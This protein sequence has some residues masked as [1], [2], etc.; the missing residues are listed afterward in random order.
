MVLAL[1]GGAI[2]ILLSLWGIKMF[3]SVVP[4][5]MLRLDQVGLDG[6]V[7]AYAILLTVGC[8]LVF[9]T[10]PALQG[11]GGDLSGGLRDGGRT[12]SVGLKHGR[13]RSSLVMGEIA[14]ALVLLISAGLLV[15]ASLGLTRVDLGFDQSNLLMFRMTLVESEYPDTVRT[16]GVQE[17]LVAG[18]GALPG[19]VEASATNILPMAGGTGTYY[20]VEG[21]PP[22]NEGERPVAQYRLVLPAYFSTMRSAVAEGRE[23]SAQDREG[24]VPVMMINQAMARNLWPEESAIGKRLVFASGAREIVGVAQDTREFGP[25][26][27]VPHMMFWPATQRLARGLSFVVRTTGDP[28][29]LAEGVREVARQVAPA[30]PVYFMQSMEQH[31]AEEM[32]GETVMGKLLGV[33]GAIALLLAVMG[34]Y[35]VMA[36]SVSQR[37]QEMGIRRALGAQNPDILKLVLRQGALLT[38]IGAVIGLALAAAA[39]RGLA[40]FL[41]G[42]SAFDPLIFAGVTV[43]LASAALAASVIPA[44]RATTVDPIVALRAE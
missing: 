17:A 41:Y 15:K 5:D 3:V 2:G 36:Y 20:E 1:L 25:E 32:S 26:D 16:I 9:G 10:A 8:G 4:A 43:T 13:L 7:L 34:V 38:G 37:T 12:G 18:L 19:V 21:R 35:G 22:A 11:T 40:T 28:L 27:E 29:A 42:V 44:R 24:T 14:L 31:V 30:Q 23:F 39:T 33:F 6:R